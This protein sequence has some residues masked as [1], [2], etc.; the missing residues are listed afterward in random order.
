MSPCWIALC[1]DR[2]PGALDVVSTLVTGDVRFVGALTGARSTS[3][4]WPP[5]HCE[6]AEP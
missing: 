5:W 6:T 2:P 4:R 1:P 3:P